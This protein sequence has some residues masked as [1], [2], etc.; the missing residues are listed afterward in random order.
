MLSLKHWFVR[1]QSNFRAQYLGL[2]LVLMVV[3]YAHGMRT[4][5]DV[6][7]M[8]MLGVSL[9]WCFQTIYPYTVLHP[10]TVPRMPKGST[11]HISILIH[12]VYQYNDKYDAL[13]AQVERC[14][15]DVLLLLETDSNWDNAMQPLSEIY[16]YAT[17]EIR[18]DTYGIMLLS[19]VK[20]NYSSILHLVS[21]SIPAAEMILP[22]GDTT[23]QILGIHPKP[24]VPGEAETSIPKEREILSAARRMME[25]REPNQLVIGDLNDVAWSDVSKEFRKITGFSDPREGRGFYSTFPTYLPMRIPLDHVFC[26]PGMHIVD[27][28]KLKHVGSDHF[29][30]YVSFVLS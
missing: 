30:V 4:G 10:T 12:N 9:A 1:G 25:S 2:N 22:I 29:P 8:I 13:I 24:P 20:P 26:S 11:P 19:K 15:P 14:T 23:L 18:D 27:F 16:P 21:D 7:Y 6:V 3:L 28:K 17:K 5:M